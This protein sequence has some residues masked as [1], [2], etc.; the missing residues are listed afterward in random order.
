MSLKIHDNDLKGISKHAE[1]S[2]KYKLFKVIRKWIETKQSPV[3]WETLI[4]AIEGPIV[5]NKQKADDIRKYLGLP[6]K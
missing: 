1:D 3:T 4:S 5:E 6:M 2:E